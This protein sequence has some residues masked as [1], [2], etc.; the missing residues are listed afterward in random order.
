MPIDV[1]D[2]IQIKQWMTGQR[3]AKA[4]EAV[5][6]MARMQYKIVSNQIGQLNATNHPLGVMLADSQNWA[7]AADKLGIVDRPRM[8]PANPTWAQMTAW[9]DQLHGAI[10][11]HLANIRLSKDDAAKRI[12]IDKRHLNRVIREGKLS[13]GA[14]GKIDGSEVDRYKAECAKASK[15]RRKRLLTPTQI[16]ANK[17]RE[18]RLKVKAKYQ[19]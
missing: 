3:D 8:L 1:A 19:L 11:K 5:V 18:N 14:D 4:L 9:M 10:V 13:A 17:R 12:G 6:K 15:K 7:E 16:E 2:V